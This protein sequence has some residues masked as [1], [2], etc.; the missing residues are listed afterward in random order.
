MIT[1][2]RKPCNIHKHDQYK[3][4]IPA[5]QSPEQAAVCKPGT[6]PYVPTGQRPEHVEFDI[7]MIEPNAP[8]GHGVGAIEP[9]GQ[10]KLMM[11][12]K[13]PHNPQIQFKNKFYRYV[14]RLHTLEGRPN[15]HLNRQECNFQQHNRRAI[16]HEEHC[17]QD[18]KGLTQIMVKHFIW[19]STL[20]IIKNIWI[21]EN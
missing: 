18:T 6:D 13:I 7:P 17:R 2:Q 4:Y 20:V 5:L 1:K 14:F 16:P 21:G 12:K 11:R 19:S 3:A 8:T 15:T 10:K 9:I